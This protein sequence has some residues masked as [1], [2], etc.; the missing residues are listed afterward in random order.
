MS[1]LDP[2]SIRRDR[3][4]KIHQI[5]LGCA[6][7]FVFI[8]GVEAILAIDSGAEVRLFNISSSD[9]WSMVLSDGRDRVKI[10]SRGDVE[11]LE[12]D[13]VPSLDI[14][15]GGVVRIDARRDGE[16]RR[17]E[18]RGTADGVTYDYRVDGDRR[19]FDEDGRRWL[20]DI[21]I[22]ALRDGGIQA[23]ERATRI[24]ADGGPHALDAELA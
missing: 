2:P 5:V 17:L 23:R 4:R 22:E 10:K 24:F 15:E 11:V 7:G 16:R 14:A 8:L 20:G 1:R 6:V 19:D 21:L 3:L 12:D 13:A 9:R 18:A